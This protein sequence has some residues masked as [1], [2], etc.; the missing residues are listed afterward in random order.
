LQIE[1]ISDCTTANEVREELKSLSI[2][3][4]DSYGSS[5]ERIQRLPKF[6]KRLAFKILFWLSH[7]ER[8]LTRSELRHCVAVRS[9]RD[10]IDEGDIANTDLM[11]RLCIGLIDFD[12]KSNTIRLVHETLSEYLK[13]KLDSNECFSDA[14]KKIAE[15]CLLYIRL[16]GL[17]SYCH[18]IPELN[19][20]L[21]KF[22]FLAYTARYWGYHASQS[23]ADEVESLTLELFEDLPRLW[24][25]IQ[26]D[27]Y[28]KNNFDS[29]I[30]GFPKSPRPIHVAAGL[31]WKKLVNKLLNKSPNDMDVGDD[32]G[33]TALYWAILSAYE[34][35]TRRREG[36]GNER[37]REDDRQRY[38]E[39][40]ESLLTRG[41]SPNAKANDGRTPLIEAIH[42]GQEDIVD[43]LAGENERRAEGEQNSSGGSDTNDKEPQRPANDRNTR[44]HNVDALVLASTI[45]SKKTVE[46]LL[47]HIPRSSLTTPDADLALHRAV[48]SLRTST[49]AALLTAGITPNNPDSDGVTPLYWAVRLNDKPMISTLR[50][51]GAKFGW[52]GPGGSRSEWRVRHESA[53]NRALG[54]A[55]GEE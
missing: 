3:L 20:R 8:P 33:K 38:K 39:V 47:Q 9:G 11:V 52:E 31:G 53:M 24:G 6:Q 29:G 54:K 4:G 41:A 7:A 19:D 22:P 50:E 1:S 34:A 26:T 35:D 14:K 25:V 12:E 45:G 42:N 5:I 2:T 21:E 55:G 23:S 30:K 37:Q 49:V 36:E 48:R 28:R 13:T 44:E 10:D 18:T 17:A 51:H 27:R 32:D 16:G 43:L 46:L 40:I 15:T